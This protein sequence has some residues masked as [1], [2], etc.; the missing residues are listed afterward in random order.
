[1]RIVFFG[2]GAFGLPTLIAL[3]EKHDVV[4]VVSQPDRPAGRKRKLTP[5]PI[6]AWAQEQNLPLIKP[7][8]VN[9]PDIL[10]QIQAARADANV[11]VAFGQKVSQP[12]IDSPRLGP[13]AT[14]NLHASLLP[15]YR[16]AAPINWAM[17]EGE[18]ETGNTVFALVEKMDAGDMLG[19]QATPIDPLETVGELHDRLAAL[20]PDLVLRVLNDL[21]QGTAQPQPQ[22]AARKTIAPKLSKADAW[23]DFA[24]PA[25]A[26]RNRIHG[27]TPWPGV[28]TKYRR[29]NETETHDLLLRRVEVITAQGEPGTM[30]ADGIIATGSSG[31]ASGGGGGVALLEVQPPGKR[32][33]SW[34]DFQK[35]HNLPIGTRFESGPTEA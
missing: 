24:A 35:G 3:H 22:D 18:K 15:R 19:Q 33:M 34:S 17:I 23:V 11:V 29:P 12:L 32:A 7:E 14:V 2:S 6:A 9:Q 1:M 16:G 25:E 30:N 10:E 13:T 21:E 28:R 31:G 4:L 26:V 5:T 27:L 8:N 20:G